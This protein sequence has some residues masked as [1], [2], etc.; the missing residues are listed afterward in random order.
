MVLKDTALLSPICIDPVTIC[1][2]FIF[3]GAIKAAFKLKA[4][5]SAVA[6]HHVLIHTTG[7]KWEKNPGEKPISRLWHMKSRTTVL[8]EK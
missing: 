4:A 2:S 8:P 1:Y 6:Q 5:K 3:L 7:P